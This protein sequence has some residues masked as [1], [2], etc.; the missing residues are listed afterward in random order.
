MSETTQPT[1]LNKREYT[2]MKKA[3]SLGQ[4]YPKKAVGKEM[5]FEHVE[6]QC[7]EIANYVAPIISDHERMFKK[8]E[9]TNPDTGE[10]VSFNIPRP[11]LT[12]HLFPEKES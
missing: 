6:K 2:I 12:E 3:F 9:F 10:L 1:R 5:N 8:V 7:L 4:D 11:E